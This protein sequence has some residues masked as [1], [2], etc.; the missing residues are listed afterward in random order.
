MSGEKQVFWL[1]DHPTCFALPFLLQEQ[2]LMPFFKG[3]KLL[4]LVTAALPHGIFTRF[5]IL[6]TLVGHFFA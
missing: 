4:S 5:P 2:W 1:R 3:A 6:P